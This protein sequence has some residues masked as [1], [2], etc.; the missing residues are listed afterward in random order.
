MKLASFMYEG[1][2][3]FVCL[4]GGYLERSFP[5]V[6]AV[7]MDKLLSSAGYSTTVAQSWGA[8]RPQSCPVSEDA[9]ISKAGDKFI[10]SGTCGDIKFELKESEYIVEDLVKTTNEPEDTAE[11][12]QS[13]PVLVPKEDV[14]TEDIAQDEDSTAVQE[15]VGEE[16]SD[17][18]EE[19]VEPVLVPKEDEPVEE[20]EEDT[21]VEEPEKDEPVLVPKEDEP[22]ADP[23]GDE[24]GVSPEMDA[25]VWDT[26]DKQKDFSGSPRGGMGIMR[27]NGVSNQV[28]GS[29]GKSHCTLSGSLTVPDRNP[30]NI[31]SEQP[32]NHSSN[33]FRGM[34]LGKRGQSKPTTTQRVPAV[35]SVANQQIEDDKSSSTKMGS[36]TQ[37]LHPKSESHKR[38]ADMF[39]SAP[40]AN[41]DDFDVKAFLSELSDEQK[42]MLERIPDALIGRINEFSQKPISE[43]RL[44]ELGEVYCVQNRWKICG[45]W[46]AIDITS[47]L[48]RHFYCAEDSTHFAV[49]VKTLNGWKKYKESLS[50]G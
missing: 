9:E 40:K 35:A 30:S 14:I 33:K 34:K 23:E 29:Y 8:R 21:P 27:P 43:V 49:H 44:A 18:E 15:Q 47:D 26:Q 24:P 7:P 41:G 4:D 12:E 39:A 10:V 36:D 25:P 45:K 22:T 28:L 5:G 31:I 20:S 19:V 42:A 46:Y 50:V 17:T 16:E 1:I 48:S 6:N 37:Q 32:A 38:R 2:R 3:Y 11:E 13:T